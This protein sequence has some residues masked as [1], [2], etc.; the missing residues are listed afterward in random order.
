MQHY[1][2][3]PI[4]YQVFIGMCRILKEKEGVMH[5]EIAIDMGI[6]FSIF[7]KLLS[8]KRPISEVY[9]EKIYAYFNQCRFSQYAPLLTQFVCEAFHITPTSMLYRKMICKNYED[10]L[11]YL[12]Y[13][14]K[15]KD[16]GK[17]VDL[18]NLFMSYLRKFFE[19]MLENHSQECCGYKLIADEKV[20]ALET[21]IGLAKNCIMIVGQYMDGEW[22]GKICILVC[23]Y[24]WNNE[25][26]IF[27]NPLFMENFKNY[28]VIRL[29][30][31]Q[32]EHI[33]T[34]AP[35]ER[36]SDARAEFETIYIGKLCHNAH[37]LAEII[38]KKLCHDL[39]E[40]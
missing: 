34:I 7:S 5:K 13:E 12:F 3:N 19:E 4:I 35:E 30:E 26:E 8:G 18:K 39:S 37:A 23:P 24:G 17:E 14:F 2:T 40:Q 38:F 27:S 20:R 11:R 31:E 22:K 9:E 16:I 21:Q 15:M 36:T 32:S 29:R 33:C 6:G 28:M 25:C 10:L 1:D